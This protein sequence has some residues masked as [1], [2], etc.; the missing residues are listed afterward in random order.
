MSSVVRTCPLLSGDESGLP[1]SEWP[2]TTGVGRCDW[3]AGWLNSA[4]TLS[5]AKIRRQI[6]YFSQSERSRHGDAKEADP[7]SFEQ[8]EQFD[9][10][11][12]TS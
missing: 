7:P 8:A 11:E 5:S 4:T 10:V 1:H 3:I 12:A 6:F 9:I 2:H